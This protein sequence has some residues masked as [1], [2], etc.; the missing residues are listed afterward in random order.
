MRANGAIS[1]GSVPEVLTVENEASSE[2]DLLELF[3]RMLEKVW[4]IVAAAT[5]AALIAGVYSLFIATPVYEATAKLYVLG[6]KDSVVNLQDLQIGSQVA[7]DYLEIFKIWEVHQDV[8]QT[9]GLPY[10]EKELTDML[11]VTNPT[12]TRVLH[13]TIRSND[14]QEAQQIANTFAAVAQKRIKETMRTDEPT[15]FSEA[16]IPITPISPNKTRNI[17]IGG[18][19][20]LLV[21]MGI[22]FVMFVMDDKLKSSDDLTKYVG[23]ATLA[24]MPMLGS[25]H[26]K[27]YYTRSRP[28]SSPSSRKVIRKDQTKKGNLSA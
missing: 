7:N 28:Q 10:S 16:V 4:Y 12:G 8:I 15:N 21:S 27:G 2:I 20:G 5:A 3:Y 6:S 22:I 14:P 1:E 24:V 18:L 11:T 25:V 13:I 23:I 17:L 9:L 26:D 19:V